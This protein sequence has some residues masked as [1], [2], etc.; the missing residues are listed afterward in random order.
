MLDIMQTVLVPICIHQFL[1]LSDPL[2]LL[3]L[4]TR[5][6]GLKFIEVVGDAESWSCQLRWRDLRIRTYQL[7]R[8]PWLGDICYLLVMIPG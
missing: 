5:L 8:Q 3:E 2:F 7:R 4:V 1:I 6:L